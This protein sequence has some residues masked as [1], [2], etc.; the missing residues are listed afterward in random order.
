M[1]DQYGGYSLN[2]IADNNAIN[3]KNAAS[4]ATNAKA[5]GIVP[6]PSTNAVENKPT[7]TY[8]V[9]TADSAIKDLNSK[10]STVN[11]IQQG[12]AQQQLANAQTSAT[13]TANDQAIKATEAA[14]APSQTLSQI[15]DMVAGG[16]D[17]SLTTPNSTGT[18]TTNSNLTPAEQQTGTTYAD[19]QKSID[20]A[21]KTFNT[22]IASLQTGSFPLT[23]AQQAQITSTTNLYNNMVDQIRGSYSNTIAGEGV[24]N[25][26]LGLDQYAPQT[27]LG[28]IQGVMN[29]MQT[30]IT[31]TEVTAAKA[32]SDLQSGFQTDDYNQINNSYKTLTDSLDRKT[33]L[34]NSL[35]DQVNKQATLALQQHQSAMADA[36]DEYDKQQAAIKFA[37]DNNVKL[38]FYLV[39]NTAVATADIGD[40]KAGQ[41]VDLATY[42]R[43]TGQQVGL[44][45]DQTDFSHIQTDIQTPAEQALNQNQDQFNATQDYDYKKLAQDAA[46]NG[47]YTLSAGQT[48]YDASGNVI[49]TAPGG[50]EDSSALLPYVKT[51]YSGVPYADLSSLSP[52]DKAAYAQTAIQNGYQPILDKGTADKIQAIADVKANLENIAGDVAKIPLGKKGVADPIQGLFNSG[53]KFFGDADIKSYNAWRTSVINSVQ[54]L[55]GGAGSGLR[56]NKAEID[57]AMENDLPVITGV[58]ADTHDSANAKL[59]KLSSQLDTWEKQILGGGNHA[60]PTYTSVSDY[61]KDN[62]SQLDT[63]SKL[64]TDNPSLSDSDILQIINVAPKSLS[65]VGSGTANAQGNQVKG[66]SIAAKPMSKITLPARDNTIATPLQEKNLSFGVN[67][68]SNLKVSIGSGAA[69]KNNNPGNLRNTD[70]SWMHFST[71]QEGFKALTGYLARAVSGDHKA[72]NGN[73]SIYD[74][75]S[76][77]APSSDNNNPKSYAESVAKQLGVSPNAK[78]SSLNITNWAKAIAAHESSTK[79]S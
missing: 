54:A 8:P 43:L 51:S 72:Y 60:T 44:P 33:N 70:G 59:N 53:S 66:A 52:K 40:I 18:P 17:E 79:F 63:A 76:H 45:E 24:L 31:S 47:Q 27:A 7:Q 69:V 21:T 28:N 50:G 61:L 32:I 39:G 10:Q 15:K 48:R 38:P 73:D 36:K 19:I 34:L 16:Q 37:T 49:A 46:I 62:P 2:E 23:P 13:T 58:H 14:G 42:Q 12:M 3:A 77:Y 57:A 9:V 25:T 64:K 56:I 26:R 35:N 29:D 30:K 67:V 68:P 1:P 22:S 11:N 75:F 55:A 71:P 41:V 65:N 4:D 78:I 6:A 5:N 20:D 74:F